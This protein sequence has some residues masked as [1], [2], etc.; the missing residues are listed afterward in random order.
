MFFPARHGGSAAWTHAV[1]HRLRNQRELKASVLALR[2]LR[3][4]LIERY[5]NIRT[6][7]PEGDAVWLPSRY[8]DAVDYMPIDYAL[9]REQIKPLELTRDDVAV[10]IGCGMGRTLCVLARRNVRK[11]IGIELDP[12]LAECACANA[13]RLRGRKAP[14]EVR[15]GDAAMADY[16]EG[17]VFWLYNPFGARTLQA[18]LERI[19]R[20]LEGAPRTIRIAY[21]YPVHEEVLASCGWLACTGRKQTALFLNNEVSYWSNQS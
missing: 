1:A 7:G 18:V 15:V 14:I 20:T 4:L 10:D 2:R 6:E 16:S 9:L 5:L 8:S 19:H 3:T 21:V 17:T 13:R 12:V 11:C